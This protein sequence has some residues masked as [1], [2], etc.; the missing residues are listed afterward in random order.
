MLQISLLIEVLQR[1]RRRIVV[2]DIEVIDS[3]KT[4]YINQ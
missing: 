1:F 2:I 4:L 3:Q